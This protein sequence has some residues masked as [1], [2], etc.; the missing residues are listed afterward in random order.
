MGILTSCIALVYALL[1]LAYM[2]RLKRAE[3]DWPMLSYV[4]WMSAAMLYI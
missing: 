3:L 1:G 4:D 2:N